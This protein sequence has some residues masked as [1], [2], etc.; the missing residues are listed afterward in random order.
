MGPWRDRLARWW[1]AAR[2][3]EAWLADGLIDAREDWVAFEIALREPWRLTDG[4]ASELVGPALQFAGREPRVHRHSP[5]FE[6]VV[7]E[8]RAGIGRAAAL[9][10]RTRRHAALRWL[11]SRPAPRSGDSAPLIDPLR[12]RRLQAI[13]RLDPSGLADS[14][15]ETDARLRDALGVIAAVRRAG[16]HD[17][18]ARHALAKFRQELSFEGLEEMGWWVANQVV[19]VWAWVELVNKAQPGKVMLPAEA[20]LAVDSWVGRIAAGQPGDRREVLYRR[21]QAAAA[22]LRCRALAGWTRATA[23]PD[24]LA[25]FEAEECGWARLAGPGAN[26]AEELAQCPPGV[27]TGGVE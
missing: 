18:P 27:L 25:W 9:A 10:A 19:I 8:V 5:R 12:A 3:Y 2:T 17:K 23:E 13:A 7:G 1:R 26:V 11:C 20:T 6:F 16:P 14:P 21:E 22:A 24:S 15:G 4:D